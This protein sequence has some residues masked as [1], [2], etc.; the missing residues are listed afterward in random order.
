MSEKPTRE[1][2]KTVRQQHTGN[3]SKPGAEAD[4]SDRHGGTR[5]GAE[6]VEPSSF[7]RSGKGRRKT[8]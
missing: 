4:G 3:H 8:S 7:D 6:N 1:E 5:H 2:V